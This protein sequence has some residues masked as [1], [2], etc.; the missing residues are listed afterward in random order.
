MLCHECGKETQNPRFCDRSCAARY[1]NRASPK[2]G[3]QGRCECGAAISSSARRCATCK[4]AAARQAED[5]A[6]HRLR[7]HA[8]DGAEVTVDY[9]PTDLHTRTVMS[10]WRHG[11]H[12][13]LRIDS[14]ASEAFAALFGVLASAPTWLRDVEVARYA[15][16]WRDLSQLPVPT[17]DREIVAE[18]LPIA[19]L[20][21][22]FAYWSRRAAQH[23]DPLHLSYVLDAGELMWLLLD[24][25]REG[26]VE[27]ESVI[28]LPRYQLTRE[29]RDDRALRKSYTQDRIHG[30]TVKVRVPADGRIEG[31]DR[32]CFGPGQELAVS[33]LRCH[34]SQPPPYE[35]LSYETSWTL[36]EPFDRARAFVFRAA[37]VMS[38]G[39]EGRPV[40]WATGREPAAVR[41]PPLMEIPASWIDGVLDL[42]DDP[43]G[44][45][46]THVRDWLRGK[47]AGA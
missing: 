39:S 21:R 8:L 14:P 4:E 26:D 24:G 9:R 40:P 7:L 11:H 16:L 22:A 20:P 45:A 34:L 31:P 3:L 23:A 47:S 27:V 33:L 1:N 6:A 41:Y 10:P 18:R 5:H 44:A 25:G 46:P 12:P 43:L 30:L 17:R 19:Q 29:F 13:P 35:P 36:L 38:D 2:R 32:E 37:L 15:T 28:G 42:W